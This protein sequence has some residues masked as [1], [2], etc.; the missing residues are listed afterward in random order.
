MF[1][2]EKQQ[3]QKNRS[4]YNQSNLQRKGL[5]M[6]T[7][8]INSLKRTGIETEN[9][10]NMYADL[11]VHVYTYIHVKSYLKI[12]NYFTI[13]VLEYTPKSFGTGSTFVCC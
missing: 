6:I 5:Q 7:F 8:R 13:L 12:L 11:H 4:I 1:P 3:Q 10:F 2:G 9:Q